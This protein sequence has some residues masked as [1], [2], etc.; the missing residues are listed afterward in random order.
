VSEH[1][2]R[3][4]LTGGV[5][6]LSEWMPGLRSASL[7]IWVRAG[8]LSETPGDMGISHLLE[9]MVFKGTVRRSAR[10]I[11]LVLER[12][13]GSLDAYTTREHTSYQARVLDEHVELGLD[14]LTDLVLDPLLR[15]ED[16]ELERE[17]VLE[18]IAT[19][20]DTPDD[21]VFDLHAARLWGAHPY[22]FSILGTKQTVSAFA[23]DDLR[24]MHDAWYHPANIVVAAAGHVDHERLVAQIGALFA[25]RTTG[26]PA[27]RPAP[28]ALL[29]GAGAERLERQSAQTH[30]VWGT[31]TFGHRDPRRYALVLLSNAFGGGMSSRLFQR[32]REELG[33]AYS[34]YSYQSFYH[35][36]GAVGVYLGTRPESAD[37]AEAVVRAELARL[38]A[39]GLTADEL[40][41][42]KGQVKGQIALSMESS[43]A[44]LHRLAG[45][46]LYDEPF[47]SLEEVVARVDA[48]TAE[49]VAALAASYYDPE[50][51]FLL[52]LGP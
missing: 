44:R 32:V 37:K 25:Q 41:D 8:S 11:A 26:T 38:A 20:E 45:V 28:P 6:V 40:A 52:R 30:L 13:G 39:D 27:P 10:E 21:L 19:V 14:V 24:R 47:R 31:R 42:V 3:S 49:E 1:Y 17:V 7:G 46:A 9:H 12:V 33:L 5:Q 43:S 16:L 48:V 35:D 36:A 15:G 50:R 2:R 22:G 34:V 51:Q 29:G 4:E 23:A 18:E